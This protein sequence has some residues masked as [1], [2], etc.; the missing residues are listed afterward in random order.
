MG[1]RPL[2]YRIALENQVTGYVCNHLGE[3]TIE[4]EGLPEQTYRFVRELMERAEEPAKIES[5]EETSLPPVGYE[6]FFIKT[7]EAVGQ[8]T[9][10]F[11]PDLSVCSSCMSELT[12]PE[13][14]FFHYPFTSCTYCGPRYS[15]IE[16]LPYDRSFTTMNIFLSCDTCKREY[17]DPSNR[18]FHAQ[19]IACPEC[20]PKIELRKDKDTSI[21]GNWLKKTEKALKNGEIVAVKGIGGFHLICDATQR[22]AVE[23]LRDRKR[24]PR[25]PLAI[26]ALDLET[27]EKYFEITPVE[28]ET[29]Q[30]KR[31]AIVL[32][33]PKSLLAEILPLKTLASGHQRLGIMLPY[34]PL[35]SLLFS[36]Q[37]SFLVAT[38]GNKSGFPIA[39]T[40]E[41]AYAQ[42]EG[43]ADLFVLH[44]RDIVIRVEDSVCQQVDEQCNLIRR[45]RGYVP[46]TIPYPLPPFVGQVIP[47]VL[48]V[49]AEKKNTFCLLHKNQALL[50]QHIGE[51]ENEEQ[52]ACWKEGMKHMAGLLG[53]EPQIIAYDPHPGYL[54]S[55][56][57]AQIFSDKAFIPVYHHHA[58]MAACM[59]EHGLD[60]PVIGCI[61]DGT[62]YGKDGTLWGFEILAGDYMDFERICHLQPLSLPGGEAAIRQPWMVAVSL[63]YELTQ[64]ASQLEEWVREFFPQFQEKLSFVLAQLD[65]RIP[66]PKA[67][68]AGRL[69][70]AV[71]AIL[72]LCTVNT[73]EGE[74]AILLG[75]KA[76][77]GL[78]HAKEAGSYPVI[79]QEGQWRI[80]SMVERLIQDIRNS[81]PPAIIARKFHHTV[82]EM[83]CHGALIARCRTGIQHVV[84][85]GGVW[86]NRYLLSYTKKLLAKEGLHVY[87]H[88]KIPPGDGGIA[89]G[90]AVSALWRW[91]KNV[92]VSSGEGT[93]N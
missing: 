47:A 13:M 59:A 42:L 87:T 78:E 43:I 11:P 80:A 60:T 37:F 51:M 26:M 17:E 25:K 41:E 24:R 89:F 90:Q 33:K 63:F 71:A 56:K 29:L 22:K 85:S 5:F 38:S 21:H 62:G 4:I 1:F 35:H 45:S 6:N 31:A 67:S 9:S 16:S 84:L 10:V 55:Q 46:E 66:S 40:N 7:S 81:L 54:I 69:F 34:S 3:V 39:R 18:R 48:G 14:R 2:V 68:S 79:L 86:N 57:A 52:V 88:Q 32:L 83:V 12:N 8:S 50:S 93:R 49:G 44:N 58:H 15:I 30:N 65:G 82:A 91:H 70:D 27:V 76:E 20:G 19:T 53:I 77:A 64:E 36:A 75:E 73:Y 72:G 92:S 23:K 74:A 61:L 28:R